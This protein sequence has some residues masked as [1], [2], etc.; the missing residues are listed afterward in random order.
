MVY[1]KGIE[2]YADVPHESNY[3][4]GK[5]YSQMFQVAR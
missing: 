2:V 4:I 1:V 3:V 5:Y